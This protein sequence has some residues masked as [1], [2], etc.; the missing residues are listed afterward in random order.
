MS[1]MPQAMGN[2]V[3]SCIHAAHTKYEPNPLDWQRVIEIGY[4]LFTRQD[5]ERFHEM[6][7]DGLLGRG[8]YGIFEDWSAIDRSRDGYIRIRDGLVLEG[9]IQEM[10]NEENFYNKGPYQAHVCGFFLVYHQVLIYHRWLSFHPMDLEHYC[11]FEVSLAR[12]MFITHLLISF[13]L[14]DRNFS[15]GTHIRQA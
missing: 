10:N 2:A 9:E 1:S 13:V 11:K 6:C 12:V 7:E 8:D 14:M 3:I 15:V 4:C 5:M